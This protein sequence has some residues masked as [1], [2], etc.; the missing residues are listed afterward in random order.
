M[1]TRNSIIAMMSIALMS[2]VIVMFSAC[3]K[4]E[5]TEAVDDFF[6][7]SYSSANRD[8]EQPA[9]LSLSPASPT[10]TEVGQ[11]VAFTV[12]GGQK[13]FTWGVTD[14]ASGSIIPITT[15]TDIPQAMY[16]AKRLSDN[17][18]T[19]SDSLGRAATVDITGTPSSLS[20]TPSSLTLSSGFYETN[21]P[22]GG[23]TDIAGDTI[24]F[25]VTGGVPPY[26][27]NAAAAS[28]GAV[29]SGGLYTVTDPL[30]STG[31]N[32]VTVVDADV[33]IISATVTIEYHQ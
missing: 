27:W 31:D 15:Q 24:Q 28:L 9:A 17:T 32:N 21:A 16:T 22:V 25:V 29:A 26:S 5:A 18:V 10:V 6:G 33:K 3:E 19:V 13:P 12:K 23:L 7:D 2:A 14:E 20:I 1:K 8:S 11:K 4:D 30:I